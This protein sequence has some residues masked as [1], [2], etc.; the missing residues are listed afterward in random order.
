MEWCVHC[1]DGLRDLGEIKVD[2]ALKEALL[3]C[4]SLRSAQPRLRRSFKDE[5]SMKMYIRVL[6]FRKVLCVREFANCPRS[7]KRRQR[8][9]IGR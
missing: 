1:R 7:G 6:N 3:L 2:D 5:M 4:R 8:R 9:R